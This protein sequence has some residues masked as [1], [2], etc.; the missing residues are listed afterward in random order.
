MPE[1]ARRRMQA[2]SDGEHPDADLLNGFAE[3]S[4]IG[5]ERDRVLAH[6]AACASCRE[7]VALAMPDAAEQEVAAPVSHG[8]F[9][10]PA[11]RWAAV[12]ASIV[13]VGAAVSVLVPRRS[14]NASAPEREASVPAPREDKAADEISAAQNK[15]AEAKPATAQKGLL[16]DRDRMEES[17][18][19][20]RNEQRK[21]PVLSRPPQ[22]VQSAS[23][24]LVQLAPGALAPKEEKQKSLSAGAAAPGAAIGGPVKK[25]V[26]ALDDGS[27]A[28]AWVNGKVTD[29]NGAI[30]PN[31]TVKITNTDT[32][33]TALARTDTTG[34]YR[35]P[36]APGV[37]SVE[38]NA[39]G[40]QT[41]RAALSVNG[42]VAQDFTLRPGA[43]NET[44]EVAK[45]NTAAE[46]A[47]GAV[48]GGMA[49]KTAPPPPP[50]PPP[51]QS[52]PAE[53]LRRQE[54]EAGEAGAVGALKKSNPGHAFVASKW[55]VSTKGAVERSTD[56]TN[57]DEVT[58]DPGVTFRAISSNG[59]DL[60]AGGTGGSLFHSADGGRTWSRVK[61]GT[62]GLW[63]SD[64]I[65]AVDFPS[66]QIGYVTTPSSTWYTRDGGR[67]WQRRQ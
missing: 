24:N 27:R 17:S 19:V 56:G 46:S 15:E 38:A 40:M 18:T 4:L 48:V 33:S 63:V 13:V 32:N 60:W 55:R 66:S 25:D 8:W 45:A 64:T 31:A 62:E 22:P 34:A 3:R 51:A 37:Y 42:P 39:T 16:A 2:W 43:Q 10:W 11:L 52:Q 9:R 44:V 57:W 23:G 49:M 7:I 28:V 6:L 61:V 47:H 5:A 30:V 36:V 35:V 59:G 50:P 65:T 14:Q 1:S 53:A 41:E 20:A 54:T 58:I 12:A 67:T 26:M 21:E 29:V